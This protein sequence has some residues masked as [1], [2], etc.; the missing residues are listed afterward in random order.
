MKKNL[1]AYIERE[2]DTKL[3]IAEIPWIPGAHTQAETMD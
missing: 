2:P 1:I 3:L